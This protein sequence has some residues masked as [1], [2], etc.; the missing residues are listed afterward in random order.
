MSEDILIHTGWALIERPTRRYSR[1][2]RIP[3]P[4]RVLTAPGEV[5][6]F[7]ARYAQLTPKPRRVLR[8]RAAGLSIP[9]IATAEAITE[10]NAKNLTTV[11]LK[12]LG[13]NTGPVYGRVSRAAYLLGRIEA[14]L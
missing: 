11:A 14:D 10:Q 5:D 7:R 13:L 3:K 9:E 2:T 8:A 4:Q 6:D 1:N 12:A